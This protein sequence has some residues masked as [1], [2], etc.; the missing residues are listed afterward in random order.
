MKHSQMLP[1]Q[2]HPMSVQKI[3]GRFLAPHFQVGKE[4]I[5]ATVEDWWDRLTGGSWMFADGNPA[6][7]IYAM[8]TGMD[9]DSRIPV[10]DDVV[11]VHDVATH[12]GHLVHS[13]EIE[14]LPDEETPQA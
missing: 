1:T 5:E 4:T 2:Q 10:D 12:F 14:P 3:Q 7:L 6:C 11:Y 9:P 8:R 13:S